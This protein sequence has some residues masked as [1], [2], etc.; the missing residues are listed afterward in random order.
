MCVREHLHMHYLL[1]LHTHTHTHTHTL[2]EDAHI[3]AGPGAGHYLRKY[4]DTGAG[5]KRS[6]SARHREGINA[7]YPNPLVQPVDT[8]G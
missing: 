1:I 2:L 3:T 8:H 7:G 5:V 4:G 6:M